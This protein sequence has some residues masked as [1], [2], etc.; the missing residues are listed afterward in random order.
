[1]IV[2]ILS[3]LLFT[4][5]VPVLAEGTPG[6]WYNGTYYPHAHD[7]ALCV[8]VAEELEKGIEEGY[9]SEDYA[10]YV[11]EGCLNW[12]NDRAG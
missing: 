10:E 9:F 11:M 2:R 5:S 6:L 4:S 7:A 3:A 12:A 8:A 1:M